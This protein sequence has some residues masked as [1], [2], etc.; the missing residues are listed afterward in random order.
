VILVVHNIMFVVSVH[1]L[2][3]SVSEI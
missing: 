2:F 3:G 1:G